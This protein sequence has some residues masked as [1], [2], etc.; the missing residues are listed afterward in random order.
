MTILQLFLSFFKIGLF[1]FGG[2]LAMIPLISEEIIRHGWMSDA[3]FIQIIGIAEMTPGPIAVNAA[4]FV[5]FTTAGLLGAFIATLGVALPPLLLVLIISNWLF[6][7]SDSNGMKMVFFGIKPVVVALI[8]S[9]AYYILKSTVLV[10]K[11]KYE[12]LIIAGISYL[13]GVKVKLHPIFIIA[14]A[15]I[16]GKIVS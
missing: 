8:T 16:L 12:T 15:A 13:L 14:V 2:G 10:E 5:G 6:R 3:Q 7:Y 9:A 1:S 11:I 4:T